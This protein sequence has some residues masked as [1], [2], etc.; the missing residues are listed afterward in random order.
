M[1]DSEARW[2][3]ADLNVERFWLLKHFVAGDICYNE[4]IGTEK[5]IV[6]WQNLL[7]LKSYHFRCLGLEAWGTDA[8]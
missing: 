8:C 2:V 4:G 5:T 6:F 1:S 7:K 3:P